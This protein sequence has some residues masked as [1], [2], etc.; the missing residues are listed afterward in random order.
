[1]LQN[2]SGGSTF[3]ELSKDRLEKFVVPYL[4]I[5]EQ[6]A[7][8][9][10]LGVVDSVIAKTGEVIAKTERLKKGLMQT[11]LTRGIGHKEYK[12]TP[13]GTTPKTWQVIELKD[14]VKVQGGFAFKSSD[15]V[16]NGV[17]L[18][19]IA[20]V[21]FGNIELKELAKLPFS[22]LNEY[23][24]FALEENDI[25]IVLTRPIIEGGIKAAR[26]GR[27]HIPA[28]LNQRVGRFR[29]T[30]K[31][32]IL[33]DFLFQAIFSDNFIT[34]VKKSLVT[35]NQP[36]ISPYEMEKFIIPLPPLSEQQ[37]IAEILNTVD[38][39]LEFERIE[40]ARL[41]RIKRGLMD[42]LLTGKIRVKVD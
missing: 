42:L 22:Y 30:D 26:I 23:R 34:Q 25:V 33:H 39:K 38:K 27:S 18:I 24:E 35:M 12:Q 15:Y 37:K 31:T 13:I 17:P 41:E 16:E 8:V 5:E 6:R 2:L 28:L 7:V 20:N 4:S 10:V 36:N 11:L 19:R 14:L 21:S 29:I 40:K 1:M 32:K 9:G 3:K